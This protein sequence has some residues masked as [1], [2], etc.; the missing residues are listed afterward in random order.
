MHSR[1]LRSS[2]ARVTLA[3]ATMLAVL[4]GP[5]HAQFAGNCDGCHT[6]NDPGRVNAANQASFVNNAMA[7][8]YGGQM[9]SLGYSAA[10]VNQA[11]ADIAAAHPD[12]NIST[13][14]PFA[15][16]KVISLAGKLL[17]G[18]VNSQLNTLNVTGLS[19]AEGSV[20]NKVTTGG[21]EAFTYVPG[22]CFVGTANFNYSASSTIT[23]QATSSRT[24][25]VTVGNPSSGPTFTNGASTTVQ[26]NVAMTPFNFTVSNCQSLVTFS[27]A[28]GTLPGG[29]SLSSAGV[30]SGTPAIGTTTGARALTI[31]ATYTGGAFTDQAFTLNVNLGPPDLSGSAATATGLEGTAF[32][33]QIVAAN[34]ASFTYTASGLPPGV[35]V[36][37]SNGLISGNLTVT[38]NAA[39]STVYPVTIGANNGTLATRVVNFTI[40]A[41]PVVNSAATATGF[42]GVAFNYQITA[43]K[44]PTAFTAAPLPAGLT[45]NPSTGLI[46]GTPTAVGG[47]TTA[48]VTASNANGASPPFNL[49]ITINLGPPVINSALSISGS[50]GSPVNYQIT[51]TNPPITTWGATGLPAGLS[52]DPTTGLISGTLAAGT[53]AGSPYTVTLS[54]TNSNTTATRA[55][56]INVSQFPPTITSGGTASGQT[57]VPFT[58]QI[59]A[60]NAPTGYSATGLPPGLAVDAVTGLVSGTPTA[61]GTYNATVTATN[62]SGSGSKPVTFTITLGP[63]TVTSAATATGAQGVA[64]TYQITASNSPTSFGA[65]GLPPGLSV[66][67]ATG[68]ISGTPT[69][70]G[71]FTVTISATNGSGTGSRT[72]T[73]NLNVGAPVITGPSTALAATG[74]AFS[75]QV[76]ATNAP[77][78]Y[79]ASGLPSGLTLDPVT[80]IISG[81]PQS[82]GVFIVSLSATNGTGTGTATLTLT[83]SLSA[84]AVTSPAT[85]FGQVGAPFFYLIGIA[86]GPASVSVA[87]LP[88]GLVFDTSLVAITGNPTVGGDFSITII[89]ANGTG[90][91]TFTL[92]LSV[93]FAVPAA[94]DLEVA[95]AYETAT[96]ITLPI[97]GQATQAALVTQPEHGLATI[98]GTVVTYTPANGYSGPDQFTFT[99]STPAGTSAP[100]TVKI[101][102]GTQV[103]VA[104]AATMAVELNRS[105]TLD[106]TRFIK[107][108]G[109][110]GVSIAAN[111]AHGTIALNGTLVTYT[112]RTDYFGRDSFTY[113]AYGNAGSSSAATV[114]VTVT[115]RPDPTR[116]PNVTGLVDAQAQAARRFSAAQRGN[117][118][119]RVES[120]HATPPPEGAAK[121]SSGPV[122]APAPQTTTANTAASAPNPA[123]AGNPAEGERAASA[124]PA[125]LVAPLVGLA[126]TGSASVDASTGAGGL[127]S[128]INLW[129]GGTANFGRRNPEGGITG[130]KFSTDGVSVGLDKRINDKLAVGLG[131]GY[132]RDETLVGTQGAKSK[133]KGQTF[134]V[135]GSVQPARRLFVDFVAGGGTLDFDT[136]R[137]VEVIGQS[138]T[139]S[140][141]GSQLFGSIAAGTE[142]RDEGLLVS[143]YGRV[144]FS[145]DTLKAYSESGVGDYALRFNEQQ[146][147]S[148][149]VAAGV[150]V[151]SVHDTD[152]GRVVPRARAEYR[153]ELQGESTVAL[154]Y[155]DLVG[156]PEYTITPKGTSRNALLFGVGADLVWRGGLR[157]GLDYVAQRSTGANNVQGVRLLVSQELDGRRAGSWSWQPRLFKDP[158]GV[159][160]GYT[161][162]DN[163]SR[164]RDGERLADRIYTLSVGEPMPFRL[165]ENKKLRAVLTPSITLDKFQRWQGLGRFSVG[166]SAELQYRGSAAFDATT[167]A[168]VGRASYDQFESDRRRGPRF[169]GGV[170][171]RRAV[172]DLI[173]AFAEV[174]YNVRDGRSD[175]FD[176]RDWTAKLNLD[177]SLGRRGVIYL[178]GEFRRGDMVSTGPSS[179]ANVGLAEV[180]VP[181]DAF[182][183]MDLFAYRFQGRTVLG[184]V[185]WNY[186]LGPRDSLD[187]S[188]RRVYS[189][190]LD[191]PSFDGGATRYNVNQY[192]LVYLMRF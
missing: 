174:G 151:E 165:G 52:V 154:S 58:Y 70:S 175:V 59:T 84:P 51:A 89:A 92:R 64:F 7:N 55:L 15:T 140:R 95:V 138:A 39:A 10:I 28:G 79:A 153:R 112:P 94:R 179:L 40:N 34:G 77:T 188:W 111:P 78:S 161:F 125:S 168:L 104:S 135:Y 73:I 162:D 60:A 171:A 190:P 25:S 136:T 114:T 17:M 169:F 130:L 107:G 183:G 164:G 145:R 170:N 93:A 9:G 167:F 49:D 141:K 123:K 98:S 86:N 69:V 143:P 80:G 1:W 61:V 144:D 54:A 122:P 16:N 134:A 50:E 178:S 106:L 72:L 82:S 96:P 47:P 117:F 30:L 126:T 121:V 172:T 119:R 137:P 13:T 37:P 85:A 91:A 156:G 115:G 29:M 23:G 110:T 177:Y 26:T 38:G 74:A 67:P 166:G 41:R 149:Q 159:E 2:A 127:G 90:T 18:T 113:I 180:F 57:G 150:R 21:A 22:T 160:A 157:V 71:S 103:P 53:A 108:S 182:P 139:G 155:A 76:V 4:A 133:A 129:A 45:L 32:S 173:D 191:R 109:L 63:P 12:I 62:G 120:L 65:A 184:T 20:I 36:N 27:L 102:V 33:Y 75:F 148:T 146:V 124:I 46:S 88:A 81:T 44:T 158:V 152:F 6:I 43:T 132:G 66:N 31:R 189:S 68:L 97:T 185:G 131:F 48:V 14:T 35:T 8:D 3:L 99:A 147:R 83:V 118:Q 142:F 192:S 56:T 11:V 100:G 187:L 181:D 42:T 24:V 87:N 128:G 163:V 116:D 5:A 186:P 19:V 101:T 176:T 105:A